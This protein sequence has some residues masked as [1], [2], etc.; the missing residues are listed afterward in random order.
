M[1]N[2]IWVMTA[3]WWPRYNSLIGGNRSAARPHMLR[4]VPPALGLAARRPPK[5]G[6]T[7]PRTLR[8]RRPTPLRLALIFPL[9][10]T[11]AVVR[12][13]RRCTWHLEKCKWWQKTDWHFIKGDDGGRVLCRRRRSLLTTAAPSPAAADAAA[14]VGRAPPYPTDA[15]SGDGHAKVWRFNA[16]NHI[17]KAVYY[18]R[19]LAARP[20]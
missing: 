11:A 2:E 10:N 7:P 4:Y 3:T 17:L 19:R 14:V 15:L 1:P 20:A 6:H 9:K 18:W 13:G 8:V 5:H 16:I 12:F